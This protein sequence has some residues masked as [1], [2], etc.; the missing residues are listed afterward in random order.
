[1]KKLLFS[2]VAAALFAG[3][4]EKTDEPVVYE[5]ALDTDAATLFVGDTHALAAEITPATDT[6]PVWTS[7]APEI[8][9]VDA[10]GTVTAVAAGDAVITAALQI[11]GG[12]GF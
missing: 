8:A 11:A 7:S 1:M 6:A 3:C 10:N 9:S 4:D 12:G 5:V 2:V